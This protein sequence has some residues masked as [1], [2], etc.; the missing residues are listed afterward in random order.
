[1]KCIKSIK[2]SYQ[3]KLGEV[4]RVDDKD[5]DIRVKTGLWV[6][7]PKS[8]YKLMTRIPRDEKEHVSQKKSSKNEKNLKKTRMGN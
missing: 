7:I 2:D 6:Y 4:K 8:E 5:A 1:M 3:G